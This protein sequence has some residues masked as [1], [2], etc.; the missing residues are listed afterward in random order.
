[1][2]QT[3]KLVDGL[4]SEGIKRENHPVWY[5][6]VDASTRQGTGL[7]VKN[8]LTDKLED[9]APLSGRT[10][11]WYTCG[12]TVY[13]VSHMGH[14]RAYLTFDIIRRIMEDY[15]GYQ[16]IYQMNITDIDDKIIKK[17]RINKL[18][19]D[20]RAEIEGPEKLPKLIEKVQKAIPMAQASW[21][22]RADELA[23]PLPAG[24]SSRVR[25]ERTTKLQELALKK[26][27]LDESI[28]A[29][30]KAIQAQEFNAI[31]AAGRG[32]V[33]DLLDKEKGGEVT[34]QSIFDAH[35]RK[36]EET[37]FQDCER[38]GIRP[39]D[40][41]S[42]VTEVVPEIV[43]YVQKIIDNG[44]AYVAESSVFFDTEAYKKAGH[45]YP[46]L[47]PGESAEETTAEEMAEGEG[48]LSG[49]KQGEKRSPN[50]FALW[51]FSKP[52][53]PRWPSP[54]G[55][56]R[57]GWH[58]E[59]SVMAA[60][61]LGDNM[62]IHAGGCDLRFPHHD[63]ELAQ[64]EAYWGHHQ[65]VN[66]FFHCGHLHIK[67]LKMSKSLKNFITIRQALDP[68]GDLKVTPREMRLL[69]LSNDWNDNM[70]FS[71]QS[72][73]EARERE[74]IL[75]AFFGSMDIV[76]RQNFLKSAQGFTDAD[77]ALNAAWTQTESTVHN[78]LCDNFDTPKALNAIMNLVSS[79]NQYLLKH[80]KEGRPNVTLLQKVGRYIT[81][82]FRIFGVVQGADE[83]GFVD[84]SGAADTRLVPAIDALVKF[85]DDVRKTAK[86]KQPSHA[87]LPLCD[88]LR[89][90]YLPPVG[91]RLE[92]KPDGSATQWK[93]DDPAVLVREIEN[94]REQVRL[95]KRAKLVN[96][97][98]KAE[99][100][101]QKWEPFV[102][103]PAE[104]FRKG[105]DAAQYSEFDAEGLPTKDQA[106]APLNEKQVT[107]LK[108][109]LQKY[110][111]GVEEFNNKG[112]IEFLNKT[113]AEVEALKAELAA[114]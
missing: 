37:F 18:V 93:F 78:A 86:E 80:E 40:V 106:G 109:A 6:P 108:A 90:Q 4:A 29:V 56:G 35:S 54:W 42:R 43:D 89:D 103:S 97:I 68:E 50:D 73:G 64:S 59:C 95:A 27:Q 99:K 76:F 112:G 101:V 11:K 2:S 111:K 21:Q 102:T 81:R 47:K 28:A 98:D 82:I 1:M 19:D 63:N 15:F 55:P 113:K 25:E 107:K 87:F 85:R 24:A 39:P 32:F 10:V 69:F 7:K 58:I 8:S 13:D 46:K 20:F 74:R 41:V 94:Q 49:T 70:N 60:G 92:D 66:Y 51:K 23:Q 77:K 110:S 84:K 34:D 104:Y 67:G 71:D 62:D 12:P 31:F 30:N 100:M 65:W 44:F 83:I 52:G 48:Q 96:A 22:A 3:K 114:C 88:A 14:A 36:Y 16:V 33:G 105:P 79:T 38:L 61:V 72:I 17:A 26:D 91:I 9:F 57:P 45:N 5:P 75:R 53:E